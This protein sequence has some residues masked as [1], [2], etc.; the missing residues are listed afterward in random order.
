MLSELVVSDSIPVRSE[1]PPNIVQ[2]SVAPLL[3][4]AID[5]TYRGQSVSDLFTYNGDRL[6]G[7]K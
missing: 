2:L 4:E 1:L 5:R 7:I 6:F 3:A